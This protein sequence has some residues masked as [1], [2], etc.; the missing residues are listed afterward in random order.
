MTE[1]AQGIFTTEF[2]YQS[3]FPWVSR[4]YQYCH[5]PDCIHPGWHGRSCTLFKKSMIMVSENDTSATE[6]TLL[7]GEYSGELTSCPLVLLFIF[8][9]FS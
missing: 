3:S 4:S 1:C 5:V 6:E 2:G 9:F 7:D 8:A